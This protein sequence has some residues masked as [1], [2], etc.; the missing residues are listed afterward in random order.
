MNNLQ[1]DPFRNTGRTTRIKLRALLQMS[2]NPGIWIKIE[3]HWESPQATRN[4]LMWI[5]EFC[6]SHGMKLE[7]R[8]NDQGYFLRFIK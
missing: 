7:R 8:V 4:L 2:E 5:D 1:D 3:D 6:A